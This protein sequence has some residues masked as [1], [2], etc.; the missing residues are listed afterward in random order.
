MLGS[1]GGSWLEGSGWRLGSA[2]STR[3][4]IS[5]FVLHILLIII[6]VV[7]VHFVCCSFKLLLSRP[8]SYCLFLSILLPTPVGGGGTERLCGP[9]LPNTAKL[10]QM[11][12]RINLPQFRRKQLM[13]YHTT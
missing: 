9:L 2:Q 8:I 4:C 1:S 11:E 7:T 5:L 6:V 12:S 10:Q 13:T 3:E